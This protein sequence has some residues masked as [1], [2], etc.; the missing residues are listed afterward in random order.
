M[1]SSDSGRRPGTEHQVWFHW[2][3]ADGTARSRI[4]AMTDDR[5]HADRIAEALNHP[6]QSINPAA[7]LAAVHARG[8]RCEKC[9]AWTFRP[10]YLELPWYIARLCPDC[11][12]LRRDLMPMKI[13][14]LTQVFRSDLAKYADLDQIIL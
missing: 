11:L 10:E 13:I 3:A 7:T 2:T 9:G 5:G 12:P 4:A 14:A 6:V 8:P 1:V